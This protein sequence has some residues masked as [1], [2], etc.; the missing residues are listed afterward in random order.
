VHRPLSALESGKPSSVF[1]PSVLKTALLSFV[2]FD[3]LKRQGPILQGR[4][5]FRA[6][7]TSL[8]ETLDVCRS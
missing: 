7:S 6:S 2:I 4:V 8:Y 3:T 1:A 5:W